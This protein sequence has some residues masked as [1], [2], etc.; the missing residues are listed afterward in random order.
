MS[1]SGPFL[2]A[3]E[4]ADRERLFEVG[5]PR[6]YD[7]GVR[8]FLEDDE[9][10]AVFVVLSGFV[11]V[12][13][14]TPAGRDVLIAVRGPGDLVGEMSALDAGTRSATL[15]ALED[16]EL[17]S[18]PGAR[19]LEFLEERPR[20]A[21]LLLRLLSLRLRDASG[22]VA[23][24]AAYDVVARLARRLVELAERF[25]AHENGRVEIALPLTQDEMAAWLGCSRESLVRALH[26]LREMEVIETGRRRIA[27]V[28]LERLRG[29]GG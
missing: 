26:L 11:K 9:P 20:A 24:T 23:E 4:T 7:R 12:T 19:F 2:G 8:V 27:I 3:L 10:G 17:L 29:V 16:C 14:G 18:I 6:T 13:V 22:R 21:I 1:T 5:R 25:G 15:E 28:D